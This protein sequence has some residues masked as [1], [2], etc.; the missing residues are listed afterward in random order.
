MGQSFIVGNG[1]K[2]HNDGWVYRSL[3]TSSDSA[4]D[5][6]STFQAAKVSRP[7]T[8][9]GKVCDAGMDIVFDKGRADVTAPD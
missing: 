6:A 9:L 7:L 8:F 5:I 1:A 4:H 3:Q 2:V